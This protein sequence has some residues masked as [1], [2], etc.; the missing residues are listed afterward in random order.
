MSQ[1]LS[2]HAQWQDE[3]Q[4]AQNETQDVPSETSGNSLLAPRMVKHWN[5]FPQ[6]GNYVFQ[7]PSK[8]APGQPVPS[9]LLEHE[10]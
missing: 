10:G 6:R 1:A 7:K 4:W 3:S 8:C 5:G 2:I 9:A